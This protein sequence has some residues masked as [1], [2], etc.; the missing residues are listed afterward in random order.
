MKKGL[1]WQG[2]AKTPAAIGPRA[3][4]LVQFKAALL[5]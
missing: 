1:T 5:H 3:F 4:L 2:V